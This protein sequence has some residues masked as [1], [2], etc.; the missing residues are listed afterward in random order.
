MSGALNIWLESVFSWSVI[1]KSIISCKLLPFLIYTFMEY[2]VVIIVIMTGSK[3]DGI[4]HPLKTLHDK[5]NRKKPVVYACLALIFC[6]IINF[7]YLI[8]HSIIKIDLNITMDNTTIKTEN[9]ICTYIKWFNFYDLYWPYIDAILYS[10]LPFIL[11]SIFNFI[12]IFNLRKSKQKSL[13]LR[14]Y[15]S[16]S[17]TRN[18][19]N[20]FENNKKSSILLK[21]ENLEK[22]NDV[23]AVRYSNNLNQN[24]RNS[25]IDLNKTESIQLLNIGTVSERR[26]AFVEQHKEYSL[27]VL[28]TA[29]QTNKM[30]NNHKSV[31]LF[32][33]LVDISFLFLTMPIVVLQLIFQTTQY[34][35]NGDCSSEMSCTKN[36]NYKDLLKSIFEILQYLNHS[37]NFFLYCLSGET[38]RNETKMYF[39]VILSYL[40]GFKNLVCNYN[41][42]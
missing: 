27:G 28:I 39:S 11:I 42:H 13:E 37:L 20:F 29:L 31:I 41:F 14:Q 1:E 23:L 24:D 17:L 25:A 34:Y 19:K 35:E 6:S 10:F 40:I 2:S 5:F 33:F 22:H 16:L 12:I 9:R 36:N 4:L 26:M 32:I 15:R 18:F 38:F 21:N 8:T 7:H 30:K 3:I